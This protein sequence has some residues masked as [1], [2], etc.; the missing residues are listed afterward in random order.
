MQA[1]DSNWDELRSRPFP[2]NYPTRESADRLRDEMLFHRATQVVG[3][4]L[5]AMTMWYMK[6]GS[7]AAFGAGSN[8]LVIWK[9]R[10][11]AETIV[12]TPNSDV[13]YAQGLRGP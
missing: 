10:L 7:E 2:E 12:S 13:I 6:K 3:W 5:P 1:A 8:V 11:D 4:S 9:D